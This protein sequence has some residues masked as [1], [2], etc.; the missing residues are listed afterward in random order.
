M[1][2]AGNGANPVGETQIEDSHACPS[3]PRAVPARPRTSTPATATARR[4]PR[5]DPSVADTAASVTR[6][7]K[8]PRSVGGPPTSAPAATRPDPSATAGMTAARAAT[9]ATA[10]R[11]PAVRAAMNVVAMSAAASVATTVARSAPPATVGSA[12]MTGPHVVDAARSVRRVMTAASVRMTVPHVAMTA[13]AAST[14]RLATTADSGPMPV[15][16]VAAMTAV[17]AS[18]V[19]HVMMRAASPVAATARVTSAADV[20]VATTAHPVRTA[21][22]GRRTRSV[23]TAVP[24]VTRV[25]VRTGTAPRRRS[26]RSTR[27]SCTSVCR[28]RPSTRST[29]PM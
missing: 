5:A 25:D 7:R 26:A 1:M 6:R 23:R 14:A 15:R 16:P 10:P 12:R 24:R 3:S 11:T 9:S 4:P 17:A 13:A 20:T 19:P 18:T 2:C 21:P 27:T 8:L 22:T 29:S 28:R